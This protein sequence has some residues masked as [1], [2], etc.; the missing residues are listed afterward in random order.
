MVG[1]KPSLKISAPVLTVWDRQCLED[2]ELKDDSISDGGDCRTAL[3]TP[4]LL[5]KEVFLIIS[6]NSFTFS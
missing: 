5:N 6:T 4:G 3:A 2:S 1:G